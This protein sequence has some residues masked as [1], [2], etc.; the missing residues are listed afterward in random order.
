M[1]PTTDLMYNS[2]DNER[3]NHKKDH[4][5]KT[6]PLLSEQLLVLAT[7]FTILAVLAFMKTYNMT[8]ISE[9]TQEGVSMIK[10][11]E[12]LITYTFLSLFS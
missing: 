10:T 3:E 2:I 12:L 11:D 7:N 4:L 9:C 8:L 1:T 5:K 6:F